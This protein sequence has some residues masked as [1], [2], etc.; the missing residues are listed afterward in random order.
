VERLEAAGRLGRC[1]SSGPLVGGLM[2]AHG[3]G[4]RERPPGLAAVPSESSTVG[5]QF[6]V[7][8]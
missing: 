2:R 6:A 4:E 1:R 3:S 7:G 8:W 5:I